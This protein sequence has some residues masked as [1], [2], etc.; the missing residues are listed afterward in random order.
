M[1]IRN[2]IIEQR[3]VTPDEVAPNPRNWRTHPQS[4][5]DAIRGILGQVGIAAPVIAYYSARAGNRLM[6][7]DG[8]ERMTVGVPFPCAILDVDDAEADTL[9]ATFDP[10]TAMATAN[11]EALDAL[12][13]DVTTDSPA[14]TQMLAELAEDAGLY[15]DTPTITEDDVPEPPVDP[16]TKPGDLWLLGDHR[17]LCGD[18]TKAE[19]V[20][21]LLGHR[22]PFLMVTDPPYGVEYETAKGA[23]TNDDRFDW[24]ES[25]RLFAGDVAYVWH[26]E[27]TSL[28]VGIN[29]RATG[30]EVRGRII[31]VKP[32]LTMGRGHY[33][34]QHEGAW[35]SVRKNRISKWCGDS[36]QSTV[37]KIDREDHA[38]P[39]VK[40]VECMARPIRNHG[41]PDDDVYDP[42]LGSGTTLIAA[43]QLGR[44]CYGMEI[45]PQYCDVIVKRWE[46]LT[47]K[48]AVRVPSKS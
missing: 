8:H 40:P 42:F 2:R 12:L 22:K 6:L 9:L 16:I 5:R 27:R 23:V 33:H 41:G 10:I 18:S 24:T 36:T 38:H 37:W 47:G 46:T 15:A 45:S 28:D 20:E 19:D 17:L 48:K 43:E 34:F 30:F 32:S 44:K 26:G 4:Q 11:N 35:Y 29:L 25:Y 1:N 14:L 21:R 39:T 7:I 13:R 31:W 3:L